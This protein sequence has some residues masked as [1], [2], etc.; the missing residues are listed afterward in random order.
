MN[1][2]LLKDKILACWT[3]KNIGGTIGGPFEENSEMQDITGY[4]TPKGEPLPNDDLDLQI[5]WLLT[6]ER[7]GAK[8]MDANDLANSWLLFIVPN[9]NEVRDYGC[10]RG[11][12]SG[13][14]NLCCYFYC[15]VGKHCF[16]GK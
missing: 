15:S 14:R 8:K 11:S 6:L 13:R 16:C 2:E 3:G 10:Q 7:V 1:K 9:W 4:T 12:R 5:A